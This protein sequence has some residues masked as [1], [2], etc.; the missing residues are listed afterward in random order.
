MFF[1][2]SSCFVSIFYCFYLE[3]WIHSKKILNQTKK[4]VWVLHFFPSTF[5]EDQFYFIF[6]KKKFKE[7]F[8]P[9]D[10]IGLLR[11]NLGIFAIAIAKV[12]CCLGFYFDLSGVVFWEHIHPSKLHSSWE[13]GW[14]DSSSLRI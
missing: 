5:F 10:M 9:Q 8:C 13:E 11:S 3:T 6:S 7:I 4:T 12:W 1:M 2:K 14:Q